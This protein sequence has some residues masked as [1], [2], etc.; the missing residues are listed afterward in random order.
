MKQIRFGISGAWFQLKDRNKPLD[1][2]RRYWEEKRKK[3]EIEEEE[4]DPTKYGYVDIYDSSD[5]YRQ[6]DSVNCS[7][8]G[9]QLLEE[10]VGKQPEFDEVR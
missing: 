5:E 6:I 10:M 2:I 3:P 9:I 8:K 4:F 1:S 7:K